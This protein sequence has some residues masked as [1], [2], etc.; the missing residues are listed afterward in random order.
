MKV[1]RYNPKTKE[2]DIIEVSKNKIAD[3]HELNLRVAS[4]NNPINTTIKILLD[5]ADI[6]D[7]THESPLGKKSD[8]RAFALTVREGVKAIIELQSGY[9]EY[10]EKS[11]R[12]EKTAQ[13][14]EAFSQARFGVPDFAELIVDP[15][16]LE[17]MLNQV[18]G[19]DDKNV[20]S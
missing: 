3:G 2:I 14:W 17:S 9:F 8:S 13:R 11:D 19:E 5:L 15:E 18:L 20:N 12:Y 10:K 1:Q 4:K 6:A 16:R 7:N